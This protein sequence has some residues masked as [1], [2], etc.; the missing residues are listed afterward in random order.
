[1]ANAPVGASYGMASG[2]LLGGHGLG[3]AS[4]RQGLLGRRA[5]RRGHMGLLY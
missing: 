5:M 1:M 4:R 3:L 2:S